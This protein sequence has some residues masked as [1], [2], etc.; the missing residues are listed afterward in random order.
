LATCCSKCN[1]SIHLLI[2]HFV[3]VI[4]IVVVLIIL[5][6]AVIIINN[7]LGLV[8]VA[9]SLRASIA[10]R[11]RAQS[12]AI[13]M[14]NGQVLTP[15]VLAIF[16]P[17]GIFTA[18]VKNPHTV[19][20]TAPLAAW[21]L[22]T[23]REQPGFD[24][25]FR[26][27]AEISIEG[28]ARPIVLEQKRRVDAAN[29]HAVVALARRVSEDRDFILVAET[30]S[31]GARQ[32]LEENGVAY[33]D[34]LGNSSIRLSG[35]FV[36]TG[37]AR[38][39]SSG[40][41]REPV[42]ARLAG[43]AGLVV[44]ALLLNRDRSW[45]VAEMAAEAGVSSGL[46]HRVLARLEDADVVAAAGI[47]PRKVRRI[48]EP[49]SLLD[50][51]VDEE[52]EPGVRLTAA[53]VLGRPGTP[54]ANLVS[55]RLT[56]AGTTHAITGSA[57]AAIMAPALTSVPVTQVRVTAAI[58]ADDVLTA[59]GARQVEE[60]ANLVIVQGADDTELRYRR[61]VG[62]IWLAANTRIYLDALRDPRRGSEQAQ[63]FRESVLGF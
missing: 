7:L 48:T 36:R 30:T 11:T 23:I 59:M 31:A 51:W 9:I 53:F 38:V 2:I 56:A 5:L 19:N 42:R 26:A 50:L 62:E 43:K 39:V 41:R 52:K 6:I 40:T 24:A 4:V 61:R 63:V 20:I 44:Q 28:R 13:S 25:S 18:A 46:A 33:L 60:G 22:S 27:D 10:D 14:L 57:A 34:G 55:E 47:G 3:I 8:V 37:A 45:S 49:A 35:L 12:G 16:T 54:V 29:A 17:T 32:I 58:P 1:Y 21:A 15:R